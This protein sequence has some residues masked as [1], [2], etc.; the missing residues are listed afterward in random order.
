MT[1]PSNV[2]ISLD[3]V[4]ARVGCPMPVDGMR[5]IRATVCPAAVGLAPVP[6]TPNAAVGDAATVGAT[7]GATV[8]VGW[9]V[10]VGATVG[11]CVAVG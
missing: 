9:S 2:I 6:P 4:S 3:D 5:L 8:C 11:V 10:A 1:P 7:V